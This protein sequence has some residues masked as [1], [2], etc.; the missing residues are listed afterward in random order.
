MRS[1]TLVVL[2]AHSCVTS[3]YMWVKNDE[4]W[5][6]LDVPAPFYLPT[7][8]R[9][10]T[11]MHV[12]E[13][14]DKHLRKN[15]SV[16]YDTFVRNSV[17]PPPSPAHHASADSCCPSMQLWPYNLR[18]ADLISNKEFVF[19]HI[20]PDMHNRPLLTQLRDLRRVRLR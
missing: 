4:R 16:G 9:A 2:A 11:M 5:F 12:L 13:R 18:E 7:F 14:M 15:P 1:K 19:K 17:H 3:V 10:S 8:A 20:E 6:R